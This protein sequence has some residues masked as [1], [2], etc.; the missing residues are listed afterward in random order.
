[1]GEFI[2]FLFPISHILNYSILILKDND[3]K[4]DGVIGEEAK[5]GA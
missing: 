4:C 3:K 1:L 5:R 2:P